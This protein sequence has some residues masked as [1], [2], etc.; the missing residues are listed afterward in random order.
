MDQTHQILGSTQG[1]E[2]LAVVGLVITEEDEEEMKEEEPAIPHYN[3]KL[4]NTCP[5]GPGHQYNLCSRPK[6]APLELIT[7]HNNHIMGGW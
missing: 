6:P 7:F 5:E 1:G 4:V 2:S 3:P